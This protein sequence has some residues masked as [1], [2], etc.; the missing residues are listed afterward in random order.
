MY[1]DLG[2]AVFFIGPRP[3]RLVLKKKKTEG[4]VEGRSAFPL[5]L[6]DADK[7]LVFFFNI[8]YIVKNNFNKKKIILVVCINC[9]LLFI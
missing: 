4:P 6:C 8:F 5:L 2:L 1:T 9:L 3:L 7:R